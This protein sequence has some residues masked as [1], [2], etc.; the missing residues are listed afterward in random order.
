MIVVL[1]IVYTGG[2]SYVSGC[3]FEAVLGG[4]GEDEVQEVFS[5]FEL[6]LCRGLMIR[7]AGGPGDVVI[8]VWNTKVVVCWG[9][10]RRETV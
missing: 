3:M 7:G 6:L 5:Y 10:R 9:W 1:C 4:G 8:I 2:T